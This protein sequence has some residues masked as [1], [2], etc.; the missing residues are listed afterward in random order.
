MI[1]F[2]LMSTVIS[3][4]TKHYSRTEVKETHIKIIHKLQ[5]IQNYADRCWSN[6][7]NVEKYAFIPR[8]DGSTFPHIKVVVKKYKD[9]FME[10]L[11][12]SDLFS[13]LFLGPD[14]KYPIFFG[15][16]IDRTDKLELQINADIKYVLNGGKKCRS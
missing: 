1:L 4:C 10:R 6:H 14:E 5:L 3:G 16:F 12:D 7:P 2:I 15:R 13:I 9:N 8:F 11:L